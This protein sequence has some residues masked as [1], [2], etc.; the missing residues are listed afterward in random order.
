MADR[1]LRYIEVAE[2]S[3]F[4]VDDALLPAQGTGVYLNMASSTLDTPGETNIEVPS[5]FGRAADEFEPG[6]Y[7]PSGNV[8]YPVNIRTIV[9][10]LKW[11]LGGYA[12]AAGIPTTFEE[13]TLTFTTAAD[14]DGGDYTVSL[15]DADGVVQNYVFT[16]AASAT[17]GD[18]ATQ[19]AAGTF[20]GWDAV[21]TGSD[22]VFTATF[23]ADAALGTFDAGTSGAAATFAETAAYA[24][25]TLA[26]HESWGDDIRVLPPILIRVGKDHFEDAFRSMVVE[27]ME[28]SV[29]DGLTNLTI[30]F[31]G[32]RNFT[33]V[34]Q[35]KSAVK[36]ALPKERK[37]PFHQVD[38]TIDGVLQQRKMKN[39]TLSVGNSTDAESGRYLG[40]RFPGR[41]PANARS[42]TLSTEMDF[43]DLVQLERIWGAPQGPTES[44]RPAEF[45]VEIEFNG[46]KNAD[47]LDQLLVVTLPKVHYQ[48]VETQPSGREEMTQPVTMI[49]YQGDVTLDDGVTVVHT[50]IYT[51]TTNEAPIVQAV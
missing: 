35:A 22:V 11:G 38:V 16:A 5:A 18:L 1:I 25:G 19:V 40:T 43:S 33:A 32:Q 10:F 30:E 9:N 50:D 46:G 44:S 12:F 37:I 48:T 8:V 17:T 41:V 15:P 6:F 7:S 39:L 42:A 24:P 14:T 45:P 51:K 20:S 29:E 47:G 3:A 2:Q 4:D 27:S 49:G 28:L 26:V 23:N 13:Q 36:A 21:A 31:A 34:L